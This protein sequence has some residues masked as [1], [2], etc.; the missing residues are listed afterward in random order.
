MGKDTRS[1]GFTF[2][3]CC[4]L[5]SKGTRSLISKFLF[6]GQGYK[7]TRLCTV[8]TFNIKMQGHEYAKSFFYG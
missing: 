7:F 5:E 1:Q 3:C 6:D 4:D 2:M 8:V